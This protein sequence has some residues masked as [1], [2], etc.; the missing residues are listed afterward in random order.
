MQESWYQKL[1]EKYGFA[2]C[3]KAGYFQENFPWKSAYAH[4]FFLPKNRTVI[5]FSGAF[6]PIHEGHVSIIKQSIDE[7]INRTGVTE[8]TFVLHV[9]HLEYRTSKG[10]YSEDVFIERFDILS[11]LFL[12]KDNFS[13]RG[14]EVE[15]IYE[16][17]VNHSCSRNFTRLYTELTDHGNDVYFLSG[18][19]RANYALTFIDEGKCIIAGRD[20]HINFKKYKKLENNRIWFLTGN[21]SMSSTEIRNNDNRINN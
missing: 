8:G 18:G 9:D 2:F 1:E 11:K 12:E 6:Y 7:V 16:D 17:A 15:V 10:L 3:V 4:H 21:N 20:T 5:Q 13:Y 19:D 14:F